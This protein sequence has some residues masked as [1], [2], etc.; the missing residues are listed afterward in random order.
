[1]GKYSTFKNRVQP[2]SSAP[3]AVAP[4]PGYVDP[5]PP[6]ESDLEEPAP[7]P[8]PM[9][10]D[11][12]VMAACRVTLAKIINDPKGNA[13]AKIQAIKLLTSDNKLALIDDE[14]LMAELARRTEARQ[15]G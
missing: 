15:R 8:L 6:E 13:L 7:P 4:V 3:R 10:T 9:E 5:P 2:G 1:M 12:D 14:D 11:K